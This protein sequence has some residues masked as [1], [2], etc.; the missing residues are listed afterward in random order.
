LKVKK[1][2]KLFLNQLKKKNH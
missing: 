2:N 1:V